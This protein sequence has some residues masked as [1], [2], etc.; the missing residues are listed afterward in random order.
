MVF[1][2]V[3]DDVIFYDKI[4]IVRFL[5]FIREIGFF[6]GDYEDKLVFY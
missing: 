5:V 3:F 6:F 1:W 4:Y 2:E